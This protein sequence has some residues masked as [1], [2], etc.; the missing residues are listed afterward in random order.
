[1]PETIHEVLDV[2]VYVGVMG[3][4]VDP[5]AQLI[6]GRKPAVVQKIGDLEVGGLIAQLL[7]GNPPVLQD[8]FIT[9]Y[10]GDGAPATRRVGVTRIVGHKPEVVFVDL[11]LPEIHGPNRAVFYLDF[12][13]LACPIVR[14]RETLGP[15]G[16]RTPPVTSALRL[17]GQPVPLSLARTLSIYARAT[18]VS[19]PRH[20]VRYG[21]YLAPRGKRKVSCGTQRG[22]RRLCKLS[23]SILSRWLVGRLWG[24]LR[25]SCG[26]PSPRRCWGRTACPLWS[27]R[28]FSSLSPASPLRSCSPRPLSGGSVWSRRRSGGPGRRPLWSATLPRSTFRGFSGIGLFRPC[29]RRPASRTLG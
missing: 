19:A 24:V 22:S 17:F 4:L 13:T 1:M 2:L 15:R 12:V 23:A 18:Y 5:T 10:V 28:A 16:G 27:P 29:I 20:S 8:S 21:Y 14:D 26:L 3:Y 11:Y 25:S 7:D 9:I 6:L